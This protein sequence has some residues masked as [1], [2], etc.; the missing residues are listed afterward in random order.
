ML[1]EIEA[2]LNMQKGQYSDNGFLAGE[3]A[4]IVDFVAA[5]FFF[6]VV[7]NRQFLYSHVLQAQ[8]VD[9]PEVQGYVERLQTKLKPF[10]VE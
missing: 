2:R 10:E 3:K 4:G 8:I 1:Q 7:T 9:Y 6:G 5:G